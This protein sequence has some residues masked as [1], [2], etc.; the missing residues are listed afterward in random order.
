MTEYTMN[1][2]NDGTRIRTN[3]DV[4][5][6]VVTSVKRG[7]TVRGTEVWT[8]PADGAEVFKG[9]KWMKMSNGWMAY[10]HKGK[11]VCDNFQEVGVI[12][13]PPPPPPVEIPAEVELSF[14]SDKPITIL[15]NGVALPS[16][17]TGKI[18]LRTKG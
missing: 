2:I 10:I 4:F 5:A 7:V 15:N 8:A 17:Y 6:S 11:P 12:V 14:T 1:V 3:H 13:T 18:T 9:D 16:E